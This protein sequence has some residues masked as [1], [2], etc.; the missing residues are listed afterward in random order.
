[1]SKSKKGLGRG[2]NAMIPEKKELNKKNDDYN[3][4]SRETLININEIEPNIEQPRKN[5]NEV[6]ILE[7]ADSIKKHGII[8][9]LILQKSGEF[10]NIIAGERRWRAAKVAGLKEVPAIIKNYSPQEVLEIA[11]IENIQREDLNPIE[12][13]KAFQNLIKEFNLTQDELAEKVSKSRTSITNSLRLLRLNS[14]VQEMVIKGAISSG[15]GRSLLSLDD[16]QLQYDLAIKIQTDNLS[17]RETEKLIATIKKQKDN[18]DKREEAKEKDDQF[19]Y[20]KLEDEIKNII[21]SKVKIKKKANNKGKIEIEY[22]S[23]T[24]LERIIDLFHSINQSNS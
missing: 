15:H 5:F 8:Q 20:K 6:T 4:V 9:P 14:K 19:I 10:Y 13:A 24:D 1:M 18:K 22:Y 11:L 16:Q 3:N 12:E 23:I 2:L 21:G 17:V 7:L